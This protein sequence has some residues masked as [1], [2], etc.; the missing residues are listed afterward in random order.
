MPRLDLD[1]VQ[2]M[3]FFLL[4]ESHCALKC[5]NS[6]VHLQVVG[7]MLISRPLI[8]WTVFISAL[9]Q[10][11]NLNADFVCANF[12]KIRNPLSRFPPFSSTFCHT[13]S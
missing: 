3:D 10:R 7:E 6:S 5:P 1:A 13:F 9:Y 8:A 4:T 11:K 2:L 12:T